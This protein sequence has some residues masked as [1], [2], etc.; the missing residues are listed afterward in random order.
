MFYYALSLMPIVLP[1]RPLTLE[2][3][4]DTSSTNVTVNLLWVDV[5]L[6][7]RLALMIKPRRIDPLIIIV[8]E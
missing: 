3:A 6:D 4:N 5:G 1:V 2:K 7:V 8:A